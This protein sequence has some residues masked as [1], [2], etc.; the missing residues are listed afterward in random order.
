MTDIWQDKYVYGGQAGIVKTNFGDAPLPMF[1]PAGPKCW[2]HKQG[3]FI[4]KFF[5]EG[6][7]PWRGLRF[8]LLPRP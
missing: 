8:L 4:T 5:P 2:M 1:D 3:N 7:K 6:S